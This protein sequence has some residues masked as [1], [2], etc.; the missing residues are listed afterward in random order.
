MVKDAAACESPASNV[1]TL[2]SNF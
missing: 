2:L 1:R